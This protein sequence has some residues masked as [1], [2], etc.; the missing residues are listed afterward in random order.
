[1]LKSPIF[2]AE[3]A[4]KQAFILMLAVPML[5]ELTFDAMQEMDRS[6]QSSILAVVGLLMAAAIV[7]VFEATYQ[8]TNINQQ[9]HRLLAHLTKALLFIGISELMMLAVATIGTTENVYDDPLLWA[10]VPIYIALY[11]YD[12]WDALVSD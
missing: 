8:K 7:G 6:N 1:M 10:L 12:W 9:S 3:V 4:V 2:L 11:L 5:F